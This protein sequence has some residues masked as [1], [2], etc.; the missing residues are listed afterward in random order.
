MYRQPTTA[1]RR[2]QAQAAGATRD[3]PPVKLAF[4]KNPSK[5]IEK[6]GGFY[7]PRLHGP[8]TRLFVSAVTA[9]LLTLNFIASPTATDISPTLRASEAIVHRRTAVPGRSRQ[10][11]AVCSSVDRGALA[12]REE[13]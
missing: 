4:Y 7:I 3:P 11:R 9:T 2:I 5:P 8:R 6:G 1:L 12:G 13:G 10:R